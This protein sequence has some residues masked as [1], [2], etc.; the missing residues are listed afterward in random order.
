MDKERK[1]ILRI[2]RRVDHIRRATGF[3]EKVATELRPKEEP[4]QKELEK[5]R[6]RRR[7]S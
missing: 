7:S 1:S 4:I 5:E 6:A 3:L 2:H